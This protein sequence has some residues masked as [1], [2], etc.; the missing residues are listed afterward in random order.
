MYRWLFL[1]PLKKRAYGVSPLHFRKEDYFISGFV[2]SVSVRPKLPLYLIAA[3]LFRG[4]V[5]ALIFRCTLLGPQTPLLSSLFCFLSTSLV[6]LLVESWIEASPVDRHCN[7]G[8][9]EIPSTSDTIVKITTSQFY[10]KGRFFLDRPGKKEH[11]P[12]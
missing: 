12:F 8:V 4:L 10:K 2:C 3:A 1:G 5:I 11:H 7:S 6:L 9:I